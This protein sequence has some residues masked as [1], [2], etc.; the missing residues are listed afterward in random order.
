MGS[1]FIVK[2]TQPGALRQ[3]RGVDWGGKWEVSS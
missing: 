3:S 1:C 2:V